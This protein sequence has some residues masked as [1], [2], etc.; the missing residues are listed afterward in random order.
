MADIGETAYP[1]VMLPNLL[2]SLPYLVHT[3]RELGLMLAGEKPLA[4]F[5]DGKG[6]FPEV[7]VR[8][9]RLFDRHVA[10]GRIL[11]RDHYSDAFG[12]TPYVKHRIL[13]ALPG[14]EWRMQAMIDLHEGHAAWSPELE[15][16]ER[17]LLGYADWMNDYWV[18]LVYVHRDA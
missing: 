10:N 1:A 15:R 11:R 13:F 9:L 3:N 12:V 18:Q 4:S 17:G 14:E 6:R 8:Y 7:V 16:R 2:R 5:V